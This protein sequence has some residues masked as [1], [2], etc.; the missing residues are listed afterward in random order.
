M[1]TDILII[2]QGLA[3]SFLAHFCRQAGMQVL[4][5]DALH[6]D[7]ASAEAAGLINPI[8]GRR[9]VKS[10]RIDELL[11][12]AKAAYRSQEELLGIRF[13]HE[14]PIVRAFFSAKESNDW[15]ARASDPGFEAY[16]A[17]ATDPLPFATTCRPVHSYAAVRQSAQVDV[18]AFLEA[19]AAKAER[20]GWLIRERFEFSNLEMGA[21]N[22]RYGDIEAGNVVFCEG[23]GLKNNPF[24]QGLPMEG[25]KGEVLLVRIPG[26]PN[27]LVLKHKI[28]IAPLGGEVFWAGATYQRVFPDAM[29]SPEQAAFLNDQLRE[30]LELPYELVTHR[31]A[32]R[33]TVRDRRPLLGFHPQYPRL[34]VFNGLGTKGASLAPFWAH[35]FAQVIAG[36]CP[37]D[38]EVDIR[39]FSADPSGFLV[40]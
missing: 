20:A 19:F 27:D 39:R 40:P 5:I 38:P 33:P 14:R 37:L 11:P 15:W 34:A 16:F 32:I 23:F 30:I 28:F 9:Y 22:V 24:F 25:A 36:N 2:G 12:F 10:W 18:R 4:I 31:A 29:P 7:S 21:H 26:F 8:T 13:F 35:H 17:P 6:K 1:K 3:G